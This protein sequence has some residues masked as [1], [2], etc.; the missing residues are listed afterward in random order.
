M[1]LSIM[2]TLPQ[3]SVARFGTELGQLNSWLHTERYEMLFDGYIELH[4]QLA[5]LSSVNGSEFSDLLARISTLND[6]EAKFVLF[7]PKTLSND[8]HAQRERLHAALLDRLRTATGTSTVLAE[9]EQLLGDQLDGYATMRT[10]L[11]ENTQT[12]KYTIIG[13][14]RCVQRGE[15]SLAIDALEGL[16]MSVQHRGRCFMG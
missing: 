1:T 4:D 8:L 5:Q 11:L 6:D 12:M 15:M 3:D 16:I 10:R 7:S 2:T 14:V 13:A 9:I